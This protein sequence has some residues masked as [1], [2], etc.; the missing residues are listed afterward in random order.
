MTL[1]ELDGE[2]RF[3]DTWLEQVLSDMVHLISAA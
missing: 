1:N 3:T 2:G